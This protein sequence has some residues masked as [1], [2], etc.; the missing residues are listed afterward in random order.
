MYSC[1]ALFF[2]LGIS[3]QTEVTGSDIMNLQKEVASLQEE[4]TSVKAELVAGKF[5]ESASHH[6]EKVSYYTGL[7][8]FF[9]LFF[10]TVQP[11]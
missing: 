2:L 7:P 8:K 4:L 5:T 1:T 6:D 9:M 10:F 11:S 3:C